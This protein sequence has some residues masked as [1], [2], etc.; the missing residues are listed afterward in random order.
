MRLLTDATANLPD[1]LGKKRLIDM[2]TN[3]ATV[4]LDQIK[5]RFS[6][7]FFWSIKIKFADFGQYKLLINSFLFSKFHYFKCLES[8]GWPD[9]YSGKF[10][11]LFAFVIESSK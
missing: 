5:Q 3:I 4:I 1:L 8:F 6:L 10:C 11:Y 9:I 2:H 7:V